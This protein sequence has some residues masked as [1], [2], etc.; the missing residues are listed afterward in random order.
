LH[1]TTGAFGADGERKVSAIGNL[2]FRNGGQAGLG[3]SCRSSPASIENLHRIQTRA[4]FN[5]HFP[6]IFDDLTS[7]Q[8]LAFY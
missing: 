7:R 3:A 1:I 5:A 6:R 2:W 4:N 8:T